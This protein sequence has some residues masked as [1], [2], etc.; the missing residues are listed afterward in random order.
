M[1]NHI[2]KGTPTSKTIVT[3][4]FF[5][6]QANEHFRK[7]LFLHLLPFPGLPDLPKCSKI[8][9]QS[10]KIEVRPFSIKTTKNNEQV[11][12]VTPEGQPKAPDIRK[13][14]RWTA[15]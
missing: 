6:S 7:P 14:M 15:S 13:N 12:K 8:N 1:R 10:I 9:V 2:S 5:A 3:E 11:V 4:L